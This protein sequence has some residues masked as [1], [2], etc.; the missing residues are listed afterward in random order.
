MSLERSARCRD[1]APSELVIPRASGVAD[2]KADDT[3]VC[4]GQMHK[5][6]KHVAD[7]LGGNQKMGGSPQLAVRR[8]L[9]ID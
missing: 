3:D 7:Q 8:K 5:G 2:D 6:V 1:T 4:I 9:V